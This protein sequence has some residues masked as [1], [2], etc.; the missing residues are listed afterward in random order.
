M[1]KKIKRKID[2]HQSQIKRFSDFDKVQK[3]FHQGAVMAFSE[4]KEFIASQQADTP[5]QAKLCRF[6]SFPIWDNQVDVC[7]F[8]HNNP[9]DR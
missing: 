1:L 5:D 8:H 7:W 9:P 2:F 6:C 4:F 3:A